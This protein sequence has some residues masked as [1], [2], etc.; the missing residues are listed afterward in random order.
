[1]AALTADTQLQSSEAQIIALKMADNVHIYKD[2]IVC[3]NASGY[4]VAGADTSGYTFVGFAYED[5]DN[6]LAG[7]TAGGKTIRVYTDRIFKAVPFTG[8][9]TQATVGQP[10]FVSDSATLAAQ[11]SVSNNVA[12][13]LCVAFNSATSIDVLVFPALPGN[14]ATQTVG[15]QAIIKRLT[16]SPHPTDTYSANMTIDVTF[17]YHL[18]AGVSGTSATVTFTPSAAGSAGDV[19][20]I[21]TTA[22][23]S[24]T[25][26]ATFASTFHPSGTQ[27]TTASHFSSIMFVSDGTRWVEVARTTALA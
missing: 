24:G 14:G 20:I 9:A 23:A 2:S 8:T 3:L 22:D 17:S 19:L 4:A 25:V 13:G 1:M 21:E 10:V 6:T 12:V 5:I 18:V 27:A 7:H 16:L 15:T 26:T 11:G